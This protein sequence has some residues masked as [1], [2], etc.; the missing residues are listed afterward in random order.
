M[1]SLALDRQR[2]RQ[3][4]HTHTHTHLQD[5][6]LCKWLI[7]ER[8]LE[9]LLGAPN[10][11]GDSFPTHEQIIKTMYPMVRFV[12]QADKISNTLLEA[13]WNALDGTRPGDSL[14]RA[15]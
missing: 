5:P 13:L 14:T 11:D 6:A 15:V 1:Y 10:A 7:E 3:H 8:I 9:S 4:T 2:A 12:A